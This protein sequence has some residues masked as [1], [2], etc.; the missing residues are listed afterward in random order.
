MCKRVNLSEAHEKERWVNTR[1]RVGW[2]CAYLTFSFSDCRSHHISSALHYLT[3]LSDY[4]GA[5]CSDFHSSWNSTVIYIVTIIRLADSV[6]EQRQRTSTTSF[7]R[8][9]EHWTARTVS[10]NSLWHHPIVS[11]L[12]SLCRIYLPLNV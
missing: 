2:V 8:Q 1:V 11:N 12:H 3:I 9:S 4:A 10:A 7:E 6:N 5:E